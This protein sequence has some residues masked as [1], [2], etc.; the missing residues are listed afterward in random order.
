MLCKAFVLFGKSYESMFWSYGKVR[1][2]NNL[3]FNVSQTSF[4]MKGFG[5]EKLILS[6]LYEYIQLVNATHESSRIRNFGFIRLLKFI[7][8]GTSDS[9]TT[10]KIWEKS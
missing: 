6:L 8:F 4:V 3:N 1:F 10:C 7:P 5:G 9:N 2:R